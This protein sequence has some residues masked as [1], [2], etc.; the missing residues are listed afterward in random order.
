LATLITVLTPQGT[1]RRCDARC[2]AADKA[3]AHKSEC[4]CGGR[5]RG[6]GAD[7]ALE[8]PLEEVYAARQEIKLRPGETVQLRVGA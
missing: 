8:I 4:V 6:I 1:V 7:K 2:H 5:F 3:K